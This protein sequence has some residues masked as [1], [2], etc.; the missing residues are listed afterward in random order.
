MRRPIYLVCLTVST[1]S[2]STTHSNAQPTDIKR[3]DFGS[4]YS[5]QIALVKDAKNEEHART[6]TNYTLFPR[7]GEFKV[8]ASGRPLWFV[9]NHAVKK[10]VGKVN[11]APQESDPSYIGVQIISFYKPSIQPSARVYLFRNENWTRPQD[12]T[13]SGEK[14][15]GKSFAALTAA[16]FLSFHD[17]RN[18]ECRRT[19]KKISSEC[20]QK[21]DEKFSKWHAKV[22]RDAD[23][24]WD[25]GYN[26]WFK[27]D[28]IENA[29]LKNYLLRFTPRAYLS[30]G[31]VQESSKPVLF[32]TEVSDLTKIRIRTFAPTFQDSPDLFDNDISILFE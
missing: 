3:N 25:F 9:I 10:D 15:F 2:L 13:F 24:S 22:D 14:R 7:T 12:D 4:D 1:M 20:A 21:F 32:S 27:S 30:P 11:E 26:W 19:D 28:G 17:E 31:W 23:D 6:V 16:E 29:L 8:S 5:G 18:Q